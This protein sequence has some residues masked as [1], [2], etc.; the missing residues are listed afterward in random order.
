MDIIRL[1]LKTEKAH[2]E[3]WG[4]W[5]ECIAFVRRGDMGVDEKNAS[6]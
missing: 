1:P 3:E 6:G 5:N 2:S 4:R